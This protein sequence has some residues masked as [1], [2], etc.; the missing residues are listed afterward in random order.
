MSDVN[1]ALNIRLL[2]LLRPLTA[3][4]C[5]LIRNEFVSTLEGIKIKLH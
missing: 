4:N 2:Q 1:A 3:V 5:A